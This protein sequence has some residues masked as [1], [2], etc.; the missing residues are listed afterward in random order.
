MRG[1]VFVYPKHR[2]C[3]YV[4][5]RSRSEKVLWTWL[6][7]LLLGLVTFSSLTEV[8]GTFSSE[9]SHFLLRMYMLQGQL[10]AWRIAYCV[11]NNK[12][13]T[14]LSECKYHCVVCKYEFKSVKEKQHAECMHERAIYTRHLG[15]IL[16]WVSI[17]HVAIGKARVGRPKCM[18]EEFVCT[19]HRWCRYVYGRS[20][21]EKLLWTWLYRLLRG[22]VKFLSLNRLFEESGCWYYSFEQ[23][24]NRN[25][26]PP[27][28]RDLESSV[29]CLISCN[30]TYNIA[31][32]K[33]QLPR[34]I[35]AIYIA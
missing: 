3:G 33:F 32:W 17:H 24:C 23:I 29:I 27:T 19:K 31:T 25:T 14:A 13:C 35:G 9:D 26:H 16:G 22:L 21:S 6:Y 18:G 10:S 12:L 28:P 2:W 11:W 8:A 4:Y 20:R 30:C 1:E 15:W 7:R 34:Y 5:E